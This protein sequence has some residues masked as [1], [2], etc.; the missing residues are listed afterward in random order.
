MRNF[1]VIVIGG[2]E[3]IV[4]NNKKGSYFKNGRNK[5]YIEL[6]LYEQIVKVDNYGLCVIKIKKGGKQWEK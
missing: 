2:Q 1:L 5:V 4:Y 6:P 3:K